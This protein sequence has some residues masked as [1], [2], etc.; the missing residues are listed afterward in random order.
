MKI[1]SS[2]ETTQLFDFNFVSSDDISKIIYLMDS[3]K[4][5]NGAIPTKIVKLVNKKICKDLTNSI[6]ECIK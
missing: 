3:T 2:V 4:K 6:H 1:K 5:M